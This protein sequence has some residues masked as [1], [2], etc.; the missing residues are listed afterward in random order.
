VGIEKKKIAIINLH[1]CRKEVLMLS[2]KVS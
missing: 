2:I 1:N